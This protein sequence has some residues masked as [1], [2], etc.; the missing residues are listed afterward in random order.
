MKQ[1]KSAAEWVPI[2]A[3]T[4][5]RDNPRQNDQAVNAVADSIKR[6][7]FASPIIA[8]MDGEVIAGHTRLKAAQALG[9]DRVPV[10]YMDLDPADAKLLALADNKVGEIADWDDDRLSDILNELKAD[11]VDLDGLGWSE[12]ELAEIMALG[13]EMPEEEGTADEI[14]PDA[15]VYSETGQVYQLGPHRLICGDCRELE[16]VST[17]MDGQEIN[18]AFTSPPYASQRTYDESSGFKPIKPDAYVEWFEAVQ[19][20]VRAHL[21]EDGSWFVNIKEHCDDGQRSLYVKDLTLAHV[22][23]WDWRF[24]DEFCWTRPSPPGAWPDRFKNGFELVFHF[25]T[26]RAK[27]RPK[28]VG[29]LSES[30][31]VP[32]S[33]VGA[34]KSGPNGEYWNL[35]EQTKQGVALPSNVISVSGVES[36][37]GHTAA[38]P[39]G[40]PS[41]FIKAY[42]DPS[43]AVFDPFLGSGTTL[44]AAAKEGRVCYGVEISPGYCDIIRRRW[45]AYAN[46]AG[47]DAGEGAL[48]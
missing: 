12:D 2:G 32:S 46:Q 16:T 24:V 15:V 14:D 7:G 41:F 13:E 28:S 45:T 40:L 27:F 35:S 37:T 38:F 39:V 9:L 23:R 30:V 3:L 47:L 44:I 26:G 22:R 33:K 31:P 4:P 25:S 20:N 8:R 36:G 17:L 21:A 34:N 18:V 29:H 48:E 19:S 11:G 1:E 6:F 10:R 5:W 43:D 42:S